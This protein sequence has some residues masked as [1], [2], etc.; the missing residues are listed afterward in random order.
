M[1]R[2]IANRWLWLLLFSFMCLLSTDAAAQVVRVRSC[3]KKPSVSAHTRHSRLRQ[4]QHRY[5]SPKK[6]TVSMSTENHTVV[7]SAS[8]NTSD[9]VDTDPLS[10]L[11]LSK[12]IQQ[13]LVSTRH[14]TP[15]APQTDMPL[16]PYTFQV[17]PLGEHYGNFGSGVLFQEVYQG[18]LKVYGAIAT[19]ILSPYYSHSLKFVGRRFIADV[20][21]VMSQKFV[22]VE[23]EVVQLT[24][25]KLFDVSLVKFYPPKGVF[26]EGIELAT[27]R[28]DENSVLVSQ[29][30]VNRSP[31]SIANRYVIRENPFVIRTTLDYPH[32]RRG[33]CGG[34][35]VEQESL[36][37]GEMP[38]ASAIHVGSKPNPFGK[39]DSVI[40]Y[41]TPVWILEKLV[42]AYHNN[43]RATVRIPYQN[44]TL[45]ELNVDE[46]ISQIMLRDDELT[47]LSHRSINDHF[48]SEGNR[49]LAHFSYGDLVEKIEILAPR[50]IDFIVHR[51]SWDEEKNFFLFDTHEDSKAPGTI[52]RY[53]MKKDQITRLDLQ[54][55]SEN[56]KKPSFKERITK[57]LPYR[58]NP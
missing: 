58:R 34:L 39:K 47:I 50:Y 42:E 18:Y 14:L 11:D 33:Y 6:T 38:K 56:N 57:L 10:E 17:R 54:A 45:L 2:L 16:L 46:Y 43:G 20:F 30:F 32:D 37:K 51:V 40:G 19:H 13:K 29:G 4:K 41:A 22:P 5:N 25:T 53:D 36:L 27:H 24:P 1:K 28:P 21:D 15:L 35:L 31:V 3:G 49:I 9:R 12:M 44:R 48:S 26:L 52:Y 23:A 55:Q 8:A 7:L